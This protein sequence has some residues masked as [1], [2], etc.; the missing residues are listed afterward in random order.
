MD[1]SW[2]DT[3]ADY[4]G[5]VFGKAKCWG[6]GWLWNWNRK[7][8]LSKQTRVWLFTLMQITHF[9]WNPI[10]CYII[11]KL[12]KNYFLFRFMIIFR[13]QLFYLFQNWFTEFGIIQKLKI[14]IVLL[15]LTW[16]R[17]SGSVHPHRKC[18]TIFQ[19]LMY[20]IIN[21]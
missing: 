15:T 20:Y 8:F 5:E 17:N 19:F 14:G 12:I 1:C 11:V 2:V 6:T 18:P 4:D 7:K 9:L 13:I 3:N 21:L 10:F 16:L